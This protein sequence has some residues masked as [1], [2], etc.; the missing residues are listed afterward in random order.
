MKSYLLQQNQLRV[1]G[2]ILVLSSIFASCK[3][4]DKVNQEAPVISGV[5]NLQNRTSNLDKA[6]LA[7][8]IYIKGRNL[9]SLNK[10]TIGSVE[11]ALKDVF[12][13]DTAVT[14]KIP[15]ELPSTSANPIYLETPYGNVT[16]NFTIVPPAPVISEAP[17]MASVGDIV[18]I[19]GLYLNSVTSVTFGTVNAEIMSQTKN[20]LMVKVPAGDTYGFI[21]LVGTGGT[22]QSAAAFGFRATIYDDAWNPLY[23]T[24]VSTWSALTTYSDNS[25]EK[26]KR[27]T[28]AIK[29]NYTASWQGWLFSKTGGASLSGFTAIKLSIWAP[30]AANN[31]TVNLSINGVTATYKTLTFVG[32][33]WNDFTVLLKDL[34]NPASFTQL[35]LQNTGNGAL[36]IYIDDIGLL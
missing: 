13:T 2:L 23:K 16:Y 34:G 19:S 15:L 33:K 3:K 18:K 14:A 6:Q 12:A 8:W 22:A 35:A 10:L 29:V 31:K 7:T 5:T 17:T 27:G 9:A 32:D 20:E 21:T 30:A 36:T 4:D 26:V 24:T 25:T 11:V 1:I 28:T